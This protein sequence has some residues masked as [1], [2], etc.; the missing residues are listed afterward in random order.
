MIRVMTLSLLAC[1]AMLTVG[2]KTQET[3]YGQ[4]GTELTMTQ[5]QT[6]PVA[7]VLADAK[8]LEGKTIRVEGDMAETCKESGC[9]AVLQ[10]DT[11]GQY[12]IFHFD[13]HPAE[14]EKII[15]LKAKGHHFIGEGR[16]EELDISEDFAKLVAESQGKSK[17]EIAAI[18]GK[19]KA[20][21]VWGTG[22]EIQGVTP[23]DSEAELKNDCQGCPD[24]EEKQIEPD[25]HHH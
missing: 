18:S 11:T 21:F 9:W 1:V 7:A 6:M 8:N 16:V 2:C 24:D 17:E 15:P 3:T 14:G 25:E 13:P 23:A 20:I 12:L 10:D 5:E 19:Q 4:F 22:A